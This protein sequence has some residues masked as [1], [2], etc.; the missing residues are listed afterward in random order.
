MARA[1]AIDGLRAEEPYAA[2]A[3]KIVAVRA[4]EVADHS[5]GVL[6]VAEIEHVHDMR[7]ATRRLRAALEVFEPC[8]PSQQFME[9][10]AEV[11]AIADALGERRDRDVTIAT[12]DRF[13]ESLASPDR[14][15][16]ASLVERLVAEQ[17]QAN[18]AL[19]TFVSAPRL[20]ALS[21]RLSELVIE[22]EALAAGAG[23]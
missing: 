14:P 2:A 9:A 8:F 19:E 11:K 20:A 21:E 12:L 6:D 1:R 4:R 15:G 16:V 22:A 7:V 10:L 18:A 13:G 5:E 3:A 17:A 23:R